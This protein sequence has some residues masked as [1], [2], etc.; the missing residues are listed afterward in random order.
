M[1]SVLLFSF[2]YISFSLLFCAFILYAG[3]RVLFCSLCW[4]ESRF[5][6]GLIFWCHDCKISSAIRFWSFMNWCI[7][8]LRW[9]FRVNGFVWWSWWIFSINEWCLLSLG[10]C[11]EY[12]SLP[13]SLSP[14][15]VKLLKGNLYHSWL[16]PF[17]ICSSSSSWSVSSFVLE[18]PCIIDK[19]NPLASASS[20]RRWALSRIFRI[21]FSWRFF[22]LTFLLQVYVL[23]RLVWMRLPSVV[24]MFSLDW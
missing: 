3:R 9:L 4:V 2:S 7:G 10:P 18:M 16:V 14:D 1:A 22:S 6:C 20:T 19:S 11:C 15:V 13:L 5:P 17:S 24:H 12:L 8:G 23:H 21:C